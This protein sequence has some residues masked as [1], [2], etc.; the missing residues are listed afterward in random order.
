MSGSM[1]SSGTS[2][3]MRTP[4]KGGGSGA[5][6]SFGARLRASS[7]GRMVMTRCSTPARR[8]SYSALVAPVSSPRLSERS[9]LTTPT[10]RDASSTW[11]VA[12]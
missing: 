1:V 2:S 10:A 6:A 3:S 9:E 12:C 4:V 11:I 5:K 7:S 8:R